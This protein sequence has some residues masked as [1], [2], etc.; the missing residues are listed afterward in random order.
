MP[1]TLLSVGLVFFGFALM[2][3]GESHRILSNDEL[4]AYYAPEL[5]DV[6]SPDQE[7][8]PYHHADSSGSLNPQYDASPQH[9]L[10]SN[11][12]SLHANG[13]YPKPPSLSRSDPKDPNS[14]FASIQESLRTGILTENEGGDA[15]DDDFE[16]GNDRRVDSVG[17]F[18]PLD[19]RAGL[20]ERLKVLK[21]NVRE[22]YRRKFRQDAP[23]FTSWATDEIKRE[24]NSPDATLS[25]DSSLNVI[26]QL[27][28]QK[29]RRQ[30]LMEKQRQIQSNDEMLTNIGKRDIGHSAASSSTG[31]LS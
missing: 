17:R 14:L 2:V 1:S 12:A 18:N 8:L 30:Q 10:R 6:Q 31:P 29:L 11:E 5:E 23:P 19:K 28:L 9:K 7:Q 4:F 3:Y 24:R 22:R 15:G 26:R 16:R 27:Y 13:P 21:S 20:G 25:V